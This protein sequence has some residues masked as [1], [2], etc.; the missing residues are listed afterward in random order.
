MKRALAIIV[1][2]L[3]VSGCVTPEDNPTNLHDLRVLAVELEPPEVLIP[4]CNAALI[5]GAAAGALDGGDIQVPPELQALLIQYA[6]KPISY[7]A[8]I[9]D[10]DGGTR[11]LHY[12]LFACSSRTDRT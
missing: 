10:N 3:G 2:V 7:S 1:M 8:L 5:A 4:G 9:Y 12:K 11:P 6:A